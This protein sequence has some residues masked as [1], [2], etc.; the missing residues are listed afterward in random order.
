MTDNLLDQLV[1]SADPHH[2]G[3]VRDLRGADR[4]L[5]EEIISTPAVTPITSRRRKRLA[6]VGLAAAT[7]L[8]V[9]VSVPTLLEDSDKPGHT[10]QVGGGTD[11]IVY[12]DAAVAVAKNNPRLLIDEPGWKVTTVYGFAK[13]SG[14][15]NFHN[16]DRDV[17]MNWYPA[18]S[19]QS[20]FDDRTEVSKR[21]SITIDGQPGSRVSYSPTDIAAMLEPEGRTFVEI[22][23]SGKFADTADVLRLFGRIKHVSVATWLAAMP[24]EVV[25]PGEATKDRDEILADIPL[26]P[27]FKKGVVKP[28]TNDLYQFGEPIV[29]RVVCGWLGEWGRASAAGDRTAEKQAVAALASARGWHVLDEMH[30]A[31]DVPEM[32]WRLADTVKIDDNPRTYQENFGCPLK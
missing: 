12:S 2:T 3:A 17:E 6:V 1:R 24:P 4:D 7:V 26:P 11:R 8:A 10:V 18:D 13:D 14:T 19:Y 28:G 32:Y 25:I 27:G 15:I 22:R 31:S 23:T 16:R 21:E 20:Y 30:K 29:S 5:L 9:A